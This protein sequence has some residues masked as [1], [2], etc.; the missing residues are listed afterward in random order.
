MSFSL[1]L[2]CILVDTKMYNVIQVSDLTI[3]FSLPSTLVSAIMVMPACFRQDFVNE[4][5][6][7]NLLSDDGALW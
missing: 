1:L 7:H 2:R 4:A 6:S 3:P 5:D